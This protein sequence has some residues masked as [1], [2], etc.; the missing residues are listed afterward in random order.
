MKS[1][2]NIKRVAD[3]IKTI[4]IQWATNI[5]REACKI[6]AQELSGVQFA[7]RDELVKFF[8]EGSKMLIDAR[9]TEPLLRHGMKY[10]KSKLRRWSGAKEISDA[11][12]EYLW[13]IEREEKVRPDIGEKLIDDGDIVFTHC[14]SSSVVKVITTARKNGKKIQVYNTETRPLYQWRL[15]SKDFLAAWVPDTMVTD[16][17][18]PFFIDNTIENDVD[19][20]K[21][22]LWSDCIKPDW[23]TI[24]KVWSFSIWLSSWHSGIPLYIIWSLL[25]ID[26]DQNIWIEERHWKELWP[27]APDGLKIV[28]YAFDMVPPKC[29]TWI[30]T[31]FWVIRPENLMKEVKKHYPRMI[32]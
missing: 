28:N 22:F 16:D 15:T 19:V 25:K 27:E 11:F 6:M 7:D 14:H 29:I 21:V 5:A 3:D 8:D 12:L 2:D 20:K 26:I 17:T 13:W 24:N 4:T 9:E 1:L 32:E 30:V 31:E 23:A 18:A 10:A